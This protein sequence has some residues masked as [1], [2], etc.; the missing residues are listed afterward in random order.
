MKQATQ[1]PKNGNTAPE[2]PAPKPWLPFRIVRR[3]YRVT[4]ATLILIALTQI[5]LVLTP[6]ADR[7]FEWLDVTAP[8]AKADYIVCLGGN[9]A[10]LLWAVDAYR[11]G[12]APKVIVSNHPVAA[13]WMHDKLVQCGIPRDR[14]MTDSASGTTEEHPGNIAH[15]PGIDPRTT[16]LLIVTSQDHSR[17]AAGCFAKAG[18]QHFSV[19]GAGFLPQKDVSYAMRV[20][21]RIQLLPYLLYEYT[22]LLQYWVMGRI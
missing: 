15:L 2:A 16:R 19:Y 11:R 10:R 20:R 17:R 12:F 6:A 21:G 18:Y 22:G 13:E 5:V 4:R 7:L 3:T 8:P 9:P 1:P 14:I